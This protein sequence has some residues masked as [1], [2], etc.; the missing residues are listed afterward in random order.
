M[1]TVDDVRFALTLCAALS[2]GLMAGFFF[3]FSASVLTMALCY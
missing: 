3:A 1:A 2:C